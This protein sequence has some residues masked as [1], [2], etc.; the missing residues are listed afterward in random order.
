MNKTEENENTL[1]VLGTNIPVNIEEEEE[2]LL[3]M[4]C[5]WWK[6]GRPLLI[7]DIVRE[8]N[9]AR[10]G[11]T[12]LLKRMVRH[13]YLED[14][15]GKGELV[16]TEPGRTTGLECMYRHQNLTQFLQMVS[17]MPEEEAE[18]DA[19][20]MEHFISARSMEGIS[21]FLKYGDVYDRTYDNM[22]LG[23]SYEDGIYELT[24]AIYEVE[25]RNPRCLAEESDCYE[26]VTR[27]EV[28]G[29]SA[30]FLLYA[31]EGKN[32]GT[33]WYNAKDTW[34]KAE[35]RDGASVLPA[36]AFSFTTSA[37]VPLTEGLALIAFTD[38]KKKPRKKDYREL[39]VHL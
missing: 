4:L 17:G 12:A 20:R 5:R 29:H 37:S 23:M 9:R 14:F 1:N 11:I 25:K 28:A 27:M 24:S 18:T 22:D 15:D 32:P 8:K 3:E 34:V 35:Q 13:G 38:G 16:L 7:P 6:E 21:N 36:T 39:N 2:D 31:R 26:R 10:R 30:C 33:L 19:C